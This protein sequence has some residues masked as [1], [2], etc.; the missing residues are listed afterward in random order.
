[1]GADEQLGRPADP[2]ALARGDRFERAC[3]IAPRL[4]LDENDDPGVFDDQIDLAA[5]TGEVT[6][7]EATSLLLEVPRR[8]VLRGAAGGM[9]P[10]RVG[11]GWQRR[12]H[13]RV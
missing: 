3:A 2:P 13:I 1:M 9:S 5:A 7:E 8:E 12:A 4:D 11:L 10:A 6:G